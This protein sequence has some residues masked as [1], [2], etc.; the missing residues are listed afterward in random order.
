MFVLFPF[1]GELISPY[2]ERILNNY[3]PSTEQ[4][5]AVLR[6]KLAERAAEK[7]IH[8]VFGLIS[9][10]PLEDRLYPGLADD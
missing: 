7:T 1:A 2:V 8:N 6:L 4:D 9:C 5:I 10:P 3:E